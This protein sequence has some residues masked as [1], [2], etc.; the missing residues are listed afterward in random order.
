MHAAD[1]GLVAEALVRLIEMEPG[2]RPFRTL[3]SPAMEQLLGSYNA[4]ADSLRPIVAQIFNVP[5]LVGAP[6]AAV[7]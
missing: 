2:E 3:V 1:T 6:M 7:Q 4:A 5:D